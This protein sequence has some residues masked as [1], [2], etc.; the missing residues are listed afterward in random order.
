MRMK[1]AA[2]IIAPPNSP[3]HSHHHQTPPTCLLRYSITDASQPL[4]FSLPSINRLER[5]FI[6]QLQWDLYISS[7]L[8]AKY[9]FALRSICEKAR[10]WVGMWMRLHVIL[11]ALRSLGDTHASSHTQSLFFL[12]THPQIP[13]T[14]KDFRKRYALFVQPQRQKRAAAAAPQQQQQR[15]GGTTDQPAAP[16][17]EE[18]SARTGRVAD[19]LRGVFSRSV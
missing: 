3:T 9:Y 12:H 2:L 16:R 14:Q 1:L 8:Y 17:A 10:V 5:L 7:S 15:P 19:D 11:F 13:I 6:A 4:Q 18:I